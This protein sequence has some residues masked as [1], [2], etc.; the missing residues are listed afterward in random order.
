MAKFYYGGQ[1]VIE[2]VMMRGQ[3]HM[4]VAVRAPDGSI[5]VHEEALNGALYRHP[6]MK[7]PVLRG[8]VALWDA[9]GLGMKALMFS[10]DVALQEGT[11]LDEVEQ[12]A[13]GAAATT[14]L[15][16]APA[17]DAGHDAKKLV[18]PADGGVAADER[19][20]I[21]GFVFGQ[22]IAIDDAVEQI[23]SVVLLATI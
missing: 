3:R 4:A 22:R 14:A 17:L 11:P 10:A 9:L 7:L 8:L 23:V 5:T 20:S 21:S 19:L 12:S 1:A 2:G 6:L 18:A 15:P 13:L 16:V